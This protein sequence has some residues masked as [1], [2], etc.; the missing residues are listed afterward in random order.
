MAHEHKIPIIALIK[1]GVKV[2]TMVQGIPNLQKIISYK[3]VDDL[4]K[5]LE[6]ELNRLRK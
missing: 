6:K 4:V 1:E 3:D 2:S 5:K